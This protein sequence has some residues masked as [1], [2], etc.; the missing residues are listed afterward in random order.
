MELLGPVKRKKSKYF[1]PCPD[2]KIRQKSGMASTAKYTA[3]SKKCLLLNGCLYTSPIQIANEKF[4][5]TLTC[6]FDSI[7]QILSNAAMDYSEYFNHIENSFNSTCEFLLVLID[8]GAM[9]HVYIH[10][11]MILKEF[12]NPLKPAETNLTFV[13]KKD[14]PQLTTTIQV[15]CNIAYMWKFLMVNEPSLYSFKTC[16]CGFS[17]VEEVSTLN[18]NHII[19]DENGYSALE[20]VIALNL[21][22]LKRC[23]CHR[24]MRE[25]INVNA[26]VFIE[27]DCRTLKKLKIPVTCKVTDFPKYINLYG[28]KLR[29][30]N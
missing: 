11:C 29:L 27:A 30:V 9:P 13:N 4:L 15:D 22:N 21:P 2:I 28:E 16:D 26:H 24:E 19:I 1:Q 25:K 10:R 23:K 8:S 5:I 20:S 12:K 6:P 14:P 17:E 7:V 3:K 18:L